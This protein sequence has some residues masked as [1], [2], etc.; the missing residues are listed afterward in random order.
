M[1][2]YQAHPTRYKG[3]LFRSRLEATWACFFDMVK[4][5]WQYEPLD[6]R[7]WVP[8]FWINLK[9]HRKSSCC[10]YHELMAEVK[11]ALTVDQLLSMKKPS[12]PSLDEWIDPAPTLLGTSPKV[13]YWVMSCGDGGGVCDMEYWFGYDANPNLLWAEASNITRWHGN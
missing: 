12:M 8:D 7:G 6:F 1:Y 10:N 5:E 11:P 13:S 2:Q 3:I 9:C 4:T